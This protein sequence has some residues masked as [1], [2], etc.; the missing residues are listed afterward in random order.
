MVSSPGYWAGVLN[1]LEGGDKNPAQTL[2]LWLD[3]VAPVEWAVAWRR[4]LRSTV[5]LGL[6]YRAWGSLPLAHL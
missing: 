5:V 2:L 6:V 1:H 3:P 4:Q